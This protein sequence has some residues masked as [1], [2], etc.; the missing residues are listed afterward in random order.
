MSTV[1]HGMKP[2]GVTKQQHSCYGCALC[3]H[4]P[5]SEHIQM[6]LHAVRFYTATPL[7]DMGRNCR[8]AKHLTTQQL[9]AAANNDH[10]KTLPKRLLYTTSGTAYRS[11]NCLRYAT[12][13]SRT[14]GYLNRATPRSYTLKDSSQ[15]LCSCPCA[16]LYMFRHVGI[17]QMHMSQNSGAPMKTELPKNAHTA[18]SYTLHRMHAMQTW[19]DPRCQTCATTNAATNCSHPKHVHA[20]SPTHSSTPTTHHQYSKHCTWAVGTEPQP[21]PH[22]HTQ[23]RQTLAQVQARLEFTAR[24]TCRKEAVLG[25]SS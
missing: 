13:M 10:R 9:P 18:V 4:M 2:R 5:T 11:T 6:L 20:R 1:P 12:Q 21:Q 3:S 25:L 7:G 23:Y 14:C 8:P 17:N 15:N 16:G 24:P 22:T 19:I